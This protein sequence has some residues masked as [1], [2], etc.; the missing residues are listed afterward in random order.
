VPVHTPGRRAGSGSVLRQVK[1][2]LE[3]KGS[4][5]LFASLN[6]T[7]MVDFMSVMVIFLLM[8]F[9]AEGQSLF[10]QPDIDPPRALLEMLNERVLVIGISAEAIA[11]EGDRVESSQAALAGGEEYRLAGL[12]Q[13]LRKQK[14]T[15]TEIHPDKPFDARAIVF[16]DRNLPYKLIRR[17]I[18]VASEEGYTNILFVVHRAA[19]EG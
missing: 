15:Y 6:L 9:S 17:V 19:A 8:N 5:T 13:A 10:N 3:A 18:S 4:R 1:R 11:V 7:S 12:A 2:S 16:A 14:A